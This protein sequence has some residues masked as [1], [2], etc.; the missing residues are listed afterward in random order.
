[1]AVVTNSTVQKLFGKTVVQ[2]LRKA[3]FEVDQTQI[4]DGEKFKTLRT[5]ERLYDF[6]VRNRFERSDAVLALG[7]GVVGDLAGF[8]AA[9]Y[10]RGI[11]LVQVPT[12][13]LAQIDSSVGGKT[14]VNHRLGK[15]L[16]GS[17]YQP[18]IVIIDPGTLVSLPARQLRSGLYEAI[19]YGVI[20]DR[21]LF[22]RISR[23]LD[24]TS[25]VEQR[26]LTRVIRR[27][28]EIKA[29]V[30]RIDEREG[31]LRRILNY[32]HTVG[33]AIEAATGYRRFLH[34]EAV[35][36]GMIAE[37]GISER[38]GLLDEPDRNTIVDL[39]RRVGK[40]PDTSTLA[41]SDI[42]SRMT[43]DKKTQGG[44]PTFVL[45]VELGRVVISSD[46]P[47]SIVRQALSDSL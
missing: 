36:S 14:A 46:V 28:C 24:S 3:G 22:D 44:C 17:F 19:K 43:L 5:A 18:T 4:G 33:H 31:G 45:P 13:L 15:N 21:N 27:C 10:H 40:L 34:G 12:T 42:I 38:M 25:R 6:L 1:V 35:A 7:G 16:I 26:E 20:A 32:G 30:V 37:S 9:T 47:L 11:P 23:Y 29:R 2:S 8:V 39:V 41:L